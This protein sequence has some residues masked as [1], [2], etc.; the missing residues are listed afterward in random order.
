M[1]AVFMGLVGH[2][3]KKNQL[4]DIVAHAHNELELA[5]DR[6][7]VKL[8]KTE[9]RLKVCYASLLSACASLY[10]MTMQPCDI[11]D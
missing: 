4:L 7:A 2:A 6:L 3:Q 11:E 9:Q 1:Q 10:L 8:Y 5:K